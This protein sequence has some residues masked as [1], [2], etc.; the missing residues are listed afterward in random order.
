MTNTKNDFS[1][2][3]LNEVGERGFL[4]RFL[5]SFSSLYKERFVIPPGDDAAVLRRPPSL[6]LSIDG[7]TQGTHFRW[8]WAGKL[9]RRYG[10]PFG[11]ALGWKLAG[12]SLSDLAAMGDVRDRW[13]MVYLGGPPSLSLRFLRD[14]Y[15]GIREQIHRFN[16]LLV[17]GDTVRAKELTLVA[18]VGGR[19]VSRPLSRFTA[20]AGDLLCVAGTVG[21]AAAGLDILEGKKRLR[22][23]DEE[24][25]F[26]ERFFKH[27]PLFEP[28]ALLSQEPGVTSLIDLSDSLKDTVDIICESSRL[29]AQVEVNHIPV[30]PLYA[31]RFQKEE[32]LL[33]GGEDY[34]LLFTLQ[35]GR[36]HRLG[37]VLKFAVVGE[38]KPKAFGVRFLNGGRLCRSLSGFQHF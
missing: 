25:T 28:A 9:K 3:T 31:R 20:Q 37:R 36:V 1:N 6:V 24:R 21:D 34:A 32:R 26:V 30:S 17:G 23:L 22:S 27:R 12:C 18:A 11:K 10:L 4:R 5:P 15:D 38:M 13:I 7:L 2:S 8:T 35:K 29:G 19:L 33:T 14:V 16:A